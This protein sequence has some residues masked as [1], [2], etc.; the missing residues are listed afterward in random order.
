MNDLLRAIPLHFIIGSGR[1][2]ST[3]LMMLLNNSNGLIA[4]PELKHIVY[5]QSKHPKNNGIANREEIE[6]F[7]MEAKQSATNPLNHFDLE[8]VMEELKEFSYQHYSELSKK[9]HLSL[10]QKNTKEVRAIFDKNNL[11]SFYIKNLIEL[12]PNAKFCI[13]IRDY[14]AFVASN[15]KSQHAFKEK[16]SAAFFAH[17]WNK[18]NRECQHW[19][20]KHPEKFHVLKYESFV[21]NP[22]IS[23]KEL[24]SFY[25]VN[26]DPNCFQYTK[27]IQPIIDQY[28]E[29][30]TIDPRILKKIEDLAKPIHASAID[31]WKLKLTSKEQR[32]VEAICRDF[33][34][35]FGY[36]QELEIS[37]MQ[38]LWIHITSSLLKWRVDLFFQLNSI[39]LHHYL[40]VTRR[41]KHNKKRQYS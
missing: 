36:T 7:L 30:D 12:F 21:Q 34:Q 33:A 38:K 35:Q 17:V 14:R 13:C 10:H 32:K 3:L 4:T 9:M 23:L 39:K 20:K 31:N 19:M 16:K 41:L 24:L 40:N 37:R 5:L 6:K 28:K 29:N 25:G 11:Y 2:G 8:C 26:Y 27:K 18:Y 1:S 22:E 15:L